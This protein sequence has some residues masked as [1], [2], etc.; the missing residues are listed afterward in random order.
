MATVAKT[1][2]HLVN[3]ATLRSSESSMPHAP[4]FQARWN[5]STRHRIV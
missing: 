1:V 2:A 3:A 5:S 4:D